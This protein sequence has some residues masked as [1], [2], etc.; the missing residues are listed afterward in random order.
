MDIIRRVKDTFGVPTLAY[1]VSGEYAMAQ[2]AIAN[3]WLSSE[4][5]SESLVGL[6]RAGA[7]AVLTYFAKQVAEE[8]AT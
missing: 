4:I 8:L 2:A 3:G 1:Q 6:K 5:V 7:D